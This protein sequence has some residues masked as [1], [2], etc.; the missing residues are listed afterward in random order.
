MS[1][2]DRKM[3]APEFL[4][5]LFNIVSRLAC[6]LG[7]S[8]EHADQL[9]DWV[10]DSVCDEWGGL[11]IYIGKG[12]H[13]RLSKRDLSIYR[14]FTGDNHQELAH[15]FGISKVWVYAIIRRVQRQLDADCKN[16]Q[17]PLL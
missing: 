2:D 4:A 11:P 17:Q 3:N 6:K 12:T 1:D 16:G 13:M 14:E 15:K 8:Q 5:D 9:A 10:V 7:L